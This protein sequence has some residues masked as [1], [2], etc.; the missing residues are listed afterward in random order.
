MTDYKHSMG[1]R[2]KEKRK[3]LKLT[4]DEISEM[5]DISVKHFGEVERGIAGLSV[6]NLIKLSEILC[7]SIDYL[8]KGEI[9]N[10]K[11]SQTLS[12]FEQIPE[13]KEQIF[14]QLIATG[15]ALIK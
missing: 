9:D 2:I 3:K 5:L 8:V 11:W 6:E 13:E 7:V 12:L 15:I 1:I 4:Q 14:K 10:N